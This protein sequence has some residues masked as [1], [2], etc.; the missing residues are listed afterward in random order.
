MDDYSHLKDAPG[1]Y[2]Q[3][4]NVDP[5]PTACPFEN[6]YVNPAIKDYYR[7]YNIRDFEYSRVEDRKDTKW[8]SVKD[9][10]LMRTWIVK[11]TVVT[12][13]R[14]PGILRSTQ[15]ISTSPPI[16]INPLRRSVD[17]MQRKNTELMETAL[18]VL[19]DRLHAVK[20]LSG[21]ILGVVRPAV[22]GGVSNYEVFFSDE[23]AKIYDSEEKQLAMQLS[24][25]I[26]EQVLL[27]FH[28]FFLK[29]KFM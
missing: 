16:Y 28:S 4:F 3:V 9:N 11:R 15:I 13:E 20:K 2:M 8:T 21:E 6:P 26:I 23:C 17:Q 12:Y 25:L 22:M 14:L 29:S 19:L 24:A 5:I 27:H 10:E 7:H 18:L 1:R